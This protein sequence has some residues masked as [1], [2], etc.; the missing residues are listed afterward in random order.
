MRK[1][2]SKSWQKRNKRQCH[3]RGCIS[4]NNNNCQTYDCSFGSQQQVMD[5]LCFCAAHTGDRSPQVLLLPISRPAPKSIRP[6]M[7]VVCNRTVRPQTPPTTNRRLLTDRNAA[8]NVSNWTVCWCSIAGM[9][10]S[11]R[12]GKRWRPLPRWPLFIQHSF[13]PVQRCT[14]R[15][16]QMFR[17]W[18]SYKCLKRK[19]QELIITR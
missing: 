19:D 6:A 8:I 17:K 10:S 14:D 1:N 9:L 3:Y 16:R 7:A 18:A 5:G 4:F 2:E 13:I 11:L 12:C 15:Q